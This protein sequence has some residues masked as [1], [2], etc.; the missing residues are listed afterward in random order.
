M[1]DELMEFILT[2]MHN[3]SKCQHCIYCTDGTDAPP[4]SMAYECIADDFCEFD[5]GDD[6]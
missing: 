3:S 6:C 2:I 5:R 1:E 4:C